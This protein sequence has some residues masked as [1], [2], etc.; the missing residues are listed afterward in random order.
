M[1]W[2]RRLFLFTT[3]LPIFFLLI[4]LFLLGG[5]S[6]DSSATQ[7]TDIVQVLDGEFGSPIQEGFVITS[8]VGYR[9]LDGFH[10]GM[11]LTT[12]FGAEI[13]AISDATVYEVNTS[14]PAVGYLG[15]ACPPSGTSFNW[16]GNFVI[17]VF[18]YEGKNYYVGYGHLSEVLVSTGERV[19]KGQVI[20]YEGSSGNSTGSHL[21]LEI[22]IGG[23]YT[24]QHKG[25]VNP[26]DL[27]NFSS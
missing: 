8:E 18:E 3:F 27:I 6:S 26:R 13:Y 2:I 9:E 20:G 17:L 4:I 10:F 19:S 21:H 16:G 5:G 25:L 12:A 1:K 11:D 24:S 23:M 7:P 22:H 14:C 15:S